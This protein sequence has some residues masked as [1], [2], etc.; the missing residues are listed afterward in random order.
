MSAARTSAVELFARPLSAE[1]PRGRRRGPSTQ[2]PAAFLPNPRG[3][4]AFCRALVQRVQRAGKNVSFYKVRQPEEL[5]GGA[6]EA[7]AALDVRMHFGCTSAGAAARGACDLPADGANGDGDGE[8]RRRLRREGRPRRDPRAT[9]AH[10]VLSK[11]PMCL[12]ARISR[13]RWAALHT[14][15]APHP[16]RSRRPRWRRLTALAWH[17]R[18]LCMRTARRGGTLLQLAL[19]RGRT[20]R[21]RGMST[22]RA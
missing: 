17:L 2:A 22:K 1:S 20:T 9:P 18:V 7:D 21:A 5:V 15:R 14:R 6:D 19:E 3:R 11:T 12:P 10:S 16:T 13:C 4:R 8:L